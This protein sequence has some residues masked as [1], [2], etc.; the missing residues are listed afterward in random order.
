MFLFVISA[1][2]FP[3]YGQQQPTDSLINSES[4]IRNYSHEST[5]QDMNQHTCTNMVESYCIRLAKALPLHLCLYIKTMNVPFPR[6]SP[7]HYTHKFWWALIFVK[8][9]YMFSQSIPVKVLP[10]CGGDIILEPESW[11]RWRICS[12]HQ[13]QLLFCGIN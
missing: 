11:I 10:S 1:L 9:D 7:S 6:A 12:S 13:F 2:W 3:G 8:A 5:C 4:N